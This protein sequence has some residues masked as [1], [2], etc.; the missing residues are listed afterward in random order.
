MGRRGGSGD[1]PRPVRRGR[2]RLAG[3]A[4][5]HRGRVAARVTGSCSD[6]CAAGSSGGATCRHPA[7]PRRPVAL[8]PAPPL[9]ACST[10]RFS[11]DSA[12]SAVWFRLSSS[13]R[14]ACRGEAGGEAGTGGSRR[15]ST[16]VG[17]STPHLRPSNRCRW[18]F[19]MQHPN[20]SPG[21][22]R[23]PPNA[24]HSGGQRGREA[25][26]RSVRTPGTCLV[27][28]CQHG[29]NQVG[30]GQGVQGAGGLQRRGGGQRRNRDTGVRQTLGQQGL[31][32]HAGP[33]GRCSSPLCLFPL[34]P[35]V[36]TP[37]R[38][39]TRP[40]THADG[41]HQGGEVGVGGRHVSHSLAPAGEQGAMGTAGGQGG[42]A[43]PK[44]KTARSTR[45]LRW[46][47][48]SRSSRMLRS[49]AIRRYRIRK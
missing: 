11:G 16:S 28:G 22:Q 30:V 41:S 36:R 39:I 25:E 6:S 47:M 26:R 49:R 9:T 45:A 37:P 4:S 38:P 27:G 33:V 35:F 31:H 3:Q 10:G 18:G 8:P 19:P 14:K 24:W 13:A 34:C 46:L 15:L 23:L 48:Q 21:E 2:P 7:L 5:L 12:L 29:G 20:H 17:P 43:A 40:A 44:S 42:R 32:R 1:R